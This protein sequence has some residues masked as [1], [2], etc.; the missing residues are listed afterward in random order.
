M[1]NL[2]VQPWRAAGATLKVLRVWQSVPIPPG[3]EGF[4]T[5][6][7]ENAPQV[8]KGPFTLTLWEE[9]PRRPVTLSNITFP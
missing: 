2:G 7:A 5:V 8:A 1:K 3:A 6:E 9:G 4:V